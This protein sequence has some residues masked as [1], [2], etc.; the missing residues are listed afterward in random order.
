MPGEE[1]GFLVTLRIAANKGK[2]GD[3]RG[4]ISF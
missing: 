3:M 2:S 1:T 4:G